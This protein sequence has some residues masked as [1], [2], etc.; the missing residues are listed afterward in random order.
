MIELG[1]SN[2]AAACLGGLVS[3]CSVSSTAVNDRAGA[4]SQI[5][6]LAAATMVL[7]T[8]VALMPLFHNLPQA[9]L[10]AIV[11]HAVAR[12]MRFG[13]LNRF[14]RFHPSQFGQALVALAWRDYP[15]DSA[16]AG[17]RGHALAA[18]VHLGRQLPFSFPPWPST[19]QGALL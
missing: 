4:R 2:V 10:G 5:S 3:G 6:S 16:W 11:I 7:I 12:L 14:I 19:G 18:S 15:R 1:A 9:V 17:S 13:E 8:L